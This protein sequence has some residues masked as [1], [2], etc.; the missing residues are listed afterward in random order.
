MYSKCNATVSAQNLTMLFLN[1]PL[2]RER[3]S[4]FGLIDDDDE[5]LDSSISS[6]RSLVIGTGGVG[7]ERRRSGGRWGKFEHVSRSTP[8]F[9]G[10]AFSTG[11]ERCSEKMDSSVK[12]PRIY[13]YGH[14]CGRSVASEVAAWITALKPPDSRSAP[15][16]TRTRGPVLRWTRG[17]RDI[18]R[19]KRGGP[20]KIDRKGRLEKRSDPYR[21]NVVVAFKQRFNGYLHICVGADTPISRISSMPNVKQRA[22]S[23][24]N[25]YFSCFPK[26]ILRLSC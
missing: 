21:Y 14:C 9:L 24:N 8:S 17:G 18:K 26:M 1:D 25:K 15:C 10:P 23:T 3:A 13:S 16:T 4:W 20:P 11:R 19:F 6:Y 12:L 2:T 22:V 7:Q 5:R